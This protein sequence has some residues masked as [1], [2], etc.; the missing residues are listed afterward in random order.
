MLFV[1]IFGNIGGPKRNVQALP[2]GEDIVVVVE[3]TKPIPVGS[4]DSVLKGCHATYRVPYFDET[5][6]R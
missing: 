2:P 4:G 6:I 1:R 3:I 5:L